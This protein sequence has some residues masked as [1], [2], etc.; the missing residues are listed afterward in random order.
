MST[1][2]EASSWGRYIWPNVNLTLSLTKCQPDPKSDQMSTWL[3]VWPNVNLTLILGEVHLTICQPDLKPDQMS[4]WPEASSW[5]VHL[6]FWTQY[7]VLLLL[8]RGFFPTKDQQIQIRP[9]IVLTSL[10][11]YIS[12]DVLWL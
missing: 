11:M 7:E 1:W 3:E 5:G 9:L 4:T 12:L 6:I 8:H 2:P 10:G